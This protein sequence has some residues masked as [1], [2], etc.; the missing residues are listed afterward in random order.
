[1][2]IYTKINFLMERLFRQINNK[3]RHVFMN[4][5]YPSWQQ[6]VYPQ[7]NIKNVI[8]FNK[9]SMRCWYF[10]PHTN[11]FFLGFDL[12]S[13][14]LCFMNSNILAK[15]KPN[16]SSFYKLTTIF[17]RVVWNLL[18]FGVGLSFYAVI[19]ATLFMNIYFL[20]ISLSCFSNKTL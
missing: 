3:Y 15:H 4:N 17:S 16:D 19:I 12:N 20:N 9:V 1:M 13:S 11:F 7:Q 14:M 6:F 5:E 18:Y 8:L 10:C 2:C